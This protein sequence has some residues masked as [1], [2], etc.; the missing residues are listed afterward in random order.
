MRKIVYLAALVFLLTACAKSRPPS[1]EMAA[2]VGGHG[3][4]YSEFEE[5]VMASV[6]EPAAGLDSRVLSRL[7][8]RYLDEKALLMLARDRGVEG[9]GRSAVDALLAEEMGPIADQTAVSAYYEAHPEDFRGPPQVRLLQIL[10]EDRE[11]AE[12]AAKAVESGESFPEVASRYSSDPTAIDQ[13]YLVIEDLPPTF[14]EVVSRLDPGEV[15]EVLAAE[16]GFHLFQVVEKLPEMTLPL[17]EAEAS[18]R[19]R[20]R[21]EASDEAFARLVEQAR[22]RYD[23]AIHVQNLPFDYSP[24]TAP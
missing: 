9:A 20:L 12:L 17:E 23:L 5:Y 11:T 2:E 14:A 1:S 13:G 8:D 16:Y 24:S 15:S 18:I 21:R 10:V 6:G 3:V 22:G 19:D 4:L 7:L